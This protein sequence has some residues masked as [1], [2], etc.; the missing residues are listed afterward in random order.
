MNVAKAAIL[1]PYPELKAVADTIIGQYPRITPMAV[2][3]VQTREIVARAIALEDKG[4]DLIIARGLQARLARA[5]VLIPVIEMRA[6]TQ[7]LAALV[8]E[9][10]QKLGPAAGER[11][12][13]GIIGFFNMFHSTEHFGELLN[14]DLKVYTATGIEQYSAL[15]DR[16]RSD[17]C[18]GVIGGEVV[19]MRAEALGMP[20]CFLSMGEESMREALESASLVGYSID[21]LKR[22][23]AE[24]STMLDNTFSAIL[25]VDAEGTAKRANRAFYQMLESE[26]DAVLERPAWEIMDQLPQTLLKDAMA[27]GREIDGELLTLHRASV[28]ASIIPVQVDG[29]SEGAI[30]TFQEGKRISELDSRLRSELARQGYVAQYSFDKIIAVNKAFQRLLELLKRLSRYPVPVLLVGESGVGKGI[31]AQ[32]IHNESLHRD[33]AFITV[34]CSIWHPDDLDEKLFGRFNTR[35]DGEPSIVEQARGGTLYLRQVELMAGETQYKLLQLAKGQYY[36]NGSHLSVPMDIRLILS[37][38]TNLHERM[39][40]GL[41]RRDLFYALNAFKVEVPPLRCRREDI[42][43]WM[44]RMLSKWSKHMARQI[45]LTQDA[46]SYLSDYDWP[47]NLDEME[48]LCQ[49]LVL[50]SDKRTVDEAAL[51]AH[52]I[53]MESERAPAERAAEAQNQRAAELV[54]LLARHHGSREKAAAELGISKTTLWRRM[55]KYGIARDLSLEP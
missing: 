35:R 5:A 54:E 8:L 20:F 53:T 39:E 50:L 26:P 44:D 33:G 37:S 25:E 2:E 3:Y 4:C 51:Q 48:S 21:L 14:V 40:A 17:G 46:Q 47:G 13:L 29:K 16:A 23:N 18:R 27:E 9:L 34:D 41:F 12:P 6:S 10:K 7:E 30:L 19:G 45:R 55:K 36:H 32:C 52:L 11:P 24:M 22:S 49:R 31:L 28:L 42:P 38:E 43:L 15:V 1:M